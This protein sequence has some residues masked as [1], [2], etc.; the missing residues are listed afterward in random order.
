MPGKDAKKMRKNDRKMPEGRRNG[1]SEPR[2]MVK[3]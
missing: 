2:N 3:I 1:E